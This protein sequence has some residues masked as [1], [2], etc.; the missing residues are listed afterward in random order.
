M[1]IATELFRAT[2][3]F[4]NC[5]VFVGVIIMVG[6]VIDNLDDLDFTHIPAIKI[7]S[8][9]ITTI[10][11]RYLGLSK[12]T[13]NA[14]TVEFRWQCNEIYTNEQF[15]QSKWIINET[16]KRKSTIQI[17]QY[18]SYVW[19]IRHLYT[20]HTHT[21]QPHPT[22]QTSAHHSRT[23]RYKNGNI[24]NINFID[25]NAPYMIVSRQLYNT[26]STNIAINNLKW[27][28]ISPILY[29]ILFI[30]FQFNT[31]VLYY[32]QFNIKLI[33]YN[34]NWPSWSHSH[35]ISISLIIT[36]SNLTN[37]DI[38]IY[39][40]C[41]DST[42]SNSI[43]HDNSPYNFNDHLLDKSKRTTPHQLT[44]HQMFFNEL[45]LHN[46]SFSL[47]TE[48]EVISLTIH[49]LNSPLQLQWLYQLYFNHCWKN[50]NHIQ[51]FR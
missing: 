12:F 5:I 40:S 3:C 27:I 45:L 51:T 17:Y 10:Y 9:L 48:L 32:N 44:N 6:Y 41:F 13:N 26:P 34:Y 2:T 21:P 35:T 14:I 30:Y 18:L 29:V 36:R 33:S 8:Q 28:S 46:A 19:H 24:S 16:I 22:Y 38:L 11:W 31:I 43:H 25:I 50:S 23:D 47:K 15:A 42:K 7:L 20:N 37:N 4:T 49:D 39:P 1:S